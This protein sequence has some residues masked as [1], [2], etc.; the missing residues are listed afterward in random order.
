M[1]LLLPWIF[2]LPTSL[3]FETRGSSNGFLHQRRFFHNFRRSGSCHYCYS[4]NRDNRDWCDKKNHR[5]YLPQSSSVS[6]SSSK[7][8]TN[9][10]RNV[11]ASS[12]SDALREHE[13]ENPAATKVIVVGAGISGLSVA[14]HLM[15]LSSKPR[16]PREPM[17]PRPSFDIE[18][19]E[20][21]DRIGGRIKPFRIDDGGGASKR[22]T[23]QQRE[24]D[25]EVWIDLGG[26]WV[27]E[28][29]PENPI[30]RLME[31]DLNLSFVGDDDSSNANTNDNDIGNGAKS[32]RAKPTK[33]K[34]N[35]FC[36]RKLKNVLFDQDGKLVSKGTVQRAK[37][38]FYKAIDDLG[39]DELDLDE[40]G[41]LFKHRRD[42]TNISYRDLVDSR[43]ELERLSDCRTMEAT[44]T[45][46]AS[47]ANTSS[48]LNSA[49]S[50]NS[51]MNYFI[52]R[53][54]ENEG[55]H[56]Q[57]VSAVLAN[58]LYR[59]SPAPDRVVKGSYRSLL[60]SVSS[61]LK[62][63]DGDA[64]G[65]NEN[66]LDQDT[67]KAA[68]ATRTITTYD[69][70]DNESRN[71]NEKYCRVRLRQ[72]TRVEK[73]DYRWSNHNSN[74]GGD[75]RISLSVVEN[76]ASLHNNG[77]HGDNPVRAAKITSTPKTKSATNPSS[78][79]LECDYCVCTVPLGVLQQRKIEFVP[80]LPPKR[81]E[82][83]DGIGMGL[84]NKIVFRF[85]FD[86]NDA[87]RNNDSNNCGEDGAGYRFW[88]NLRQFG[89]CHED[90]ALVKTYHDCTEDYYGSRNKNGPNQGSSSVSSAILVQFLAGS[91]ADRVDPPLPPNASKEGWKDDTDVFDFRKGLTDVEVIHESLE[92]LRSV[93]GSENVPDPV[94]SKV[95]RW[96]N[97]PWSCGSYSFAKVG[98]SPAMY[99]EIA[100]PLGATRSR[101]SDDNGRCCGYEDGR[102]LFAGEH[103]SKHFHSTVHGA[104]NSGRREAQRI[105]EQIR[106]NGTQ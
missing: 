96:R 14:Y 43:M 1:R 62:L 94:V 26:Q 100:S 32:K 89:I 16:E 102:L 27:H 93:F 39:D 24:E 60:E 59:G 80:S 47:S 51:T 99:D 88:G 4:S 63:K 34:A 101:G 50:L 49:T 44:T 33:K 55:G 19:L 3:S 21:R 104:W 77:G 69:N 56:L 17:S 73:I 31:D 45:R 76:E 57:E 90:P 9:G 53:S 82:A 46:M 13:R 68:A 15:K 78:S 22:S 75:E 7:S 41:N 74:S 67:R 29:S 103:T 23:K 2:F 10:I 38:I 66:R 12:P 83:I 8:E 11:Y 20:V 25:E 106:R 65:K 42:R 5:R 70:S 84:L 71:E 30:R 48:S 97:D 91:A 18:I 81:Q 6:L 79:V 28:S 37:N 36:K 85:D 92:A 52:H 58:N 95:T 86:A 105:F 87:Q 72:N 40:N 54:E 98:S 64:I 35:R 61:K